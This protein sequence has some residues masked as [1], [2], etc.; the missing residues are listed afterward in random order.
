MTA[1]EA[2]ALAKFHRPGVKLIVGPT[3]AREEQT[4]AAKLSTDWRNPQ[5]ASWREYDL[6]KR[7]GFIPSPWARA[8]ARRYEDATGREPTDDEYRWLHDNSG[9]GA[10]LMAAQ[11]WLGAANNE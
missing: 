11:E 1:D 9:R 4:S 5:P 6:R 10:S 2:L 8:F 7:L 3:E